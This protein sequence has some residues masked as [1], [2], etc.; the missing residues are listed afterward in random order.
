M[1]EPVEAIR[2][3][4]VDEAGDTV[5]FNKKGRVLIGKEGCSK[6]FI[7]GTALIE[8]PTE[9]RKELEKLRKSLL[10]DPY[11]KSI[12]SMQPE[13][14]KTGSHFHAKDDAPEV[15]YAAFKLIKKQQI[16]AWAIV[17]RKESILRQIR[18]WNQRDPLW[19]Y[20]QN[21]LYDA[22]VKRIFKTRLHQAK[23][24]IICFSTRGKNP[25]NEAL[26]EALR[27][28]ITNFEYKYDRVVD[29]CC[30][31]ISNRPKEEPCLQVID[32]LLWALQRMYEKLEKRYF[33]SVQDK[34]ELI[35]DL[36]DKRTKPYGVYYDKRNPLTLDKIRGSSKN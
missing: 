15:R 19:R 11:L 3:Y 12:P 35:I 10:A 13:A 36:E 17:R 9:L 25:R 27:K 5:I 6:Y 14:G 8:N 31:V 32:Y 20:D 33:E 29:T 21:D 4:F 22:S 28:A 34:F 30:E 7:I 18:S 26:R 23:K 16:R 2:Y 24:N 1:K